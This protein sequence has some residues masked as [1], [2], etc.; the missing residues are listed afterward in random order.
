MNDQ[1]LVLSMEAV[2]HASG[3]INGLTGALARNQRGFVSVAA[4]TDA[5]T[6]ANARATQGFDA[7][8]AAIYALSTKSL[9]GLL[10][11][12]RQLPGLS[13]L[14]VASLARF[15]LI[16]GVV[17]AALAVLGNMVQAFGTGF[18]LPFRLLAGL[19][20]VVMAALRALLSVLVALAAAAAVAG[21]AL[22]ALGVAAGT[23]LVGGFVAAGSAAAGYEAQLRHVQGVTGASVEATNTLSDSLRNIAKT[24]MFPVA[25]IAKAAY[26][27]G[28]YGLAAEQIPVTLPGMT[29]L[30]E[31]MGGD[32]ETNTA[33][34]MAVLKSFRMEMAESTRVANVFATADKRSAAQIDKL[35]ESMKFV[36]P[37]AGAMGLSIE[38]TVAP[39]MMLYDAGLGGAMAGT[40]LRMMI[41]KMISP[42]KEM[43]RALRAAGMTTAD[44][45]PDIVGLS[46]AFENLNR[47]LPQDVG[48]VMK[49]FGGAGARS[50]GQAFL[51]MR[52]QG[53]GPAL[54]E[55]Q[56]AITGTQQAFIL[57]EIQASSFAGRL[58][59]LGQAARE[60]LMVF[61]MPLLEALKPFITAVTDFANFL[62]GTTQVRG[63]AAG[64][65]E[66]VG[67]MA[68]KAVAGLTWLEQNWSTVWP[69]VWAAL[70]QFVVILGGVGGMIWGGLSFIIETVRTF[71]S[72]HQSVWDF[73][74][75]TVGFTVG[76]IVSV[77][78]FL[79]L[80]LR[81]LVSGD[82]MAQ[83][84]RVFFEVFRAIAY[85]VVSTMHDMTQAIVKWTT[86][87][88]Y[89]GATAAA[90]GAVLGLV[91]GLPNIA[92]IFM[93]MGAGILAINVG[94]GVMENRLKGLTF[95]GVSAGLG[96]VSEKIKGII[97]QLPSLG[98]LLPALWKTA[99]E[100]GG[101]F[102]AN[103]TAALKGQPLMPGGG[104]GGE[105]FM[106]SAMKASLAAGLRGQQIAANFLARVESLTAGMK[107]GI[108]GISGGGGVAGVGMMDTEDVEELTDTGG[109]IVAADDALQQAMASATSTLAALNDPVKQV[110]LTQEV[111]NRLL[112]DLQEGLTALKAVNEKVLA[113]E[114]KRLGKQVPGMLADFSLEQLKRMVFPAERMK[115]FEKLPAIQAEKMFQ[116]GTLDARLDQLAEI[117][118]MQM[119]MG[120]LNGEALALYMENMKTGFTGQEGQMETAIKWSETMA[121][122][123]SDVQQQLQQA[124][125]EAARGG[126]VVQ[127]N[128]AYIGTLQLS[129][130]A[131]EVITAGQAQRAGQA[132]EQAGYGAAAANILGTPAAA[133]NAVRA[134]EAV[135]KLGKSATQATKRLDSFV[136]TAAGLTRTH[137]G[138]T[139]L[140]ALPNPA[141]A[142]A[143]G[144]A[145]AY[146]TALTINAKQAQIEATARQIGP[147]GAA[148]A[149]GTMDY[150]G[151]R[152]GA[153]GTAGVQ[154]A[155]IPY[156]D[157][158][159][160]VA[161]FRNVGSSATL[162]PAP[163]AYPSEEVMRAAQ[164]AASLQAA[165][166]A[167][168]WGVFP[169]GTLANASQVAPGWGISPRGAQ[170]QG[171]S[172]RDIILNIYGDVMEPEKIVTY[173]GRALNEYN[174]EQQH[175]GYARAGQR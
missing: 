64:I 91:T 131:T 109:A 105:G 1:D 89:V 122:Y 71:A 162:W 31:A 148:Y 20:S 67:A 133:N 69:R 108:M 62:S 11:A 27:L 8:S 45:R 158:G 44:I 13:S 123:L 93:G 76:V 174:A 57:A 135:G 113:A 115:E 18:A 46:T 103:V 51:A 49:A 55:F 82:L 42:T 61:G 41:M 134:G 65:G 120:D 97:G 30:T 83:L 59:F 7:T 35:I 60:L 38:E 161:P 126:A 160:G 140:G 85:V 70:K 164:A 170:G 94:L 125:E 130:G 24:S 137:V 88:G 23:A 19:A 5:A 72:Q 95:E 100:A 142:A 86:A 171:S 6:A 80:A 144:A 124:K 117:A 136:T 3:V 175:Q 96:N 107:A 116:T 37:T 152:S 114:E 154:A 141:S 101:G 15:G 127:Y 50:G 9:P 53:G 112:S 68:Q 54:A 78:V 149:P 159:P 48:A 58:K 56:T 16:L 157:L 111:N 143:A 34:V 99:R 43:Q 110:A 102:G 26:Q 98:P 151:V 36:A 146:R 132:T 92:G 32:L 2:D 52:Q 169:A 10:G 66:A 4:N 74:A 63:L 29:K 90:L 129:A 139:W 167:P 118:M 165:Q 12:L 147:S 28:S 87:L 73:I 33:G 156:Q 155:A 25:D 163:T 153:L 14:S 47:A 106:A 77:L 84:P 128:M 17:G 39:L 81:Q 104:M 21:A 75:E 119:S 79:E 22:L 121:K 40:Q 168:G 166:A 150:S 145:A 138:G 172:P 173:M